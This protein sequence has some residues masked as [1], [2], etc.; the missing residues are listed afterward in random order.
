MSGTFAPRRSSTPQPPGRTPHRSAQRPGGET[1]LVPGASPRTPMP[2]EAREA[3]QGR[4]PA[5]EAKRMSVAVVT[6]AARG[7]GA[8]TVLA[9]AEA[10]W[11]V[12]AVDSTADDPVLP[13]PMATPAD[14]AGVVSRANEGAGAPGRVQAATADVRDLEAV[15]GTVAEAEQRWGGLDAAIAAAGVIAGGVPL[16]EVP[17]AQ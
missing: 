11:S 7:I 6:G 16:W 4:P 10:G 8:A 12:L 13:Y 9:L 3:P 14:L 17:L 1:L 5:R 15:T 2:P